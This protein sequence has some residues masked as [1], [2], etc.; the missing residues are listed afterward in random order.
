MSLMKLSCLVS[1]NAQAVT[2]LKLKDDVYIRTSFLEGDMDKVWRLKVNS[3]GE[4]NRLKVVDFI[5]ERLISSLVP[6][7]KT[8]PK[9]HKTK[10]ILR[11]GGDESPP[12]WINGKIAGCN[13]LLN[14]SNTVHK[15]KVNMSLDDAPVYE[16]QIESGGIFKIAEFYQVSLGD[17]V[18][19]AEVNIIYEFGFN[20][21]ANFK[22]SVTAMKDMRSLAFGGMQFQRPNLV[23]GGRLMLHSPNSE[24]DVGIDISPPNKVLNLTAN[25][26]EKTL[27][28]RTFIVKTS[29]AFASIFV[30]GY[31]SSDM[32]EELESAFYLSKYGK[33]YPKAAVVRNISSGST[34][35]IIGFFGFIP[36]RAGFDEGSHCGVWE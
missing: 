12:V 7:A 5:G 34:Y 36:Q 9:Y 6:L 4:S 27:A 20:H 13:H 15:Y 10:E 31:C 28:P 8:I 30:M 24:W 11:F 19:V 32:L 3:V 1:A 18:V 25:L 14:G 33:M 26:W 16:N 29:N 2:V 22:Y 21:F 35:G 23:K 17:G